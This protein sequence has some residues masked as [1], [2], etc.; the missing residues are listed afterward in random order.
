MQR[1]QDRIRGAEGRMRAN[2]NLSPQERGRLNGMQ[3]RSGQDIYRARHNGVQTGP[4]AQVRP[5]G[6]ARPQVQVRQAAR[7]QVTAQPRATTQ[8]RSTTQTRSTT[9]R[10]HNQ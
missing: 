5:T 2:G 8:S 9:Q 3:Q 7:P 6:P 4:T 1:E 10:R